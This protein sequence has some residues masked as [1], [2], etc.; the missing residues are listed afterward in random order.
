[1][2]V[3]S[4][5]KHAIN[6]TL[7]TK[8]FKPLNELFDLYCGVKGSTDSTDVLDTLTSGTLFYQ[9]PI[10]RKIKM[11]G[12]VTVYMTNNLRD[13]VHVYRNDTYIGSLYNSANQSADVSMAV[14]VN[15][16]D[17][18]KIGSEDTIT[19][20]SITLRGKTF[21]SPMGGIIENV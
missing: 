3:W 6:S 17:I 14:T 7:G 8:N 11:T 10:S 2:S 9:I 18:I 4:G 21:F 20:T 1:M 16:G 5:I 19:N 13:T 15:Y 12:T